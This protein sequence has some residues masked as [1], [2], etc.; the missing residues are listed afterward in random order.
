MMIPVR[1][2]TLTLVLAPGVGDLSPGVLATPV[3]RSLVVFPF[4]ALFKGR[5]RTVGESARGPRSE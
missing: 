3:P 2:I 5:C 1:A 4:I